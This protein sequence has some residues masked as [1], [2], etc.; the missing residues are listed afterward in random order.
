[1]HTFF[2]IKRLLFLLLVMIPGIASAQQG[3]YNASDPMLYQ[4]RKMA[5]INGKSRQASILPMLSKEVITDS[6]VFASPRNGRKGESCLA[7]SEKLFM[8][9]HSCK[10]GKITLYPDFSTD[11]GFSSSATSFI[12]GAGLGAALMADLGKHVSLGGHVKVSQYYVPSFSDAIMR[13]PGLTT[14]MG[15]AWYC[16][17]QGYRLLDYDF[18]LNYGFMKY[19][20]LEGGIGRNF[21]GD[22]YR[23]MF[24]SD[25]SFSYPYLKLT[26]SVWHIK[27]INLYAMLTNDRDNMPSLSKG[28]EYKYGSFHYLSWDV[29]KRVNI[30]FFETIIWQNSD[31]T[32]N[33]GFDVNYINPLIFYRPVEF[34]LGS[35]DNSMMGFSMKVKVGKKNFFYG[36]F[37]MDDIIWSEFTKGSLNR[38]K[39]WIHPADSVGNYGYWT[40]KQ[41]WQIGFISYDIF[42][43]QGLDLQFEYN[44]ARPYTYSH[45]RPEVNYTQMS[46]PLAHPAGANFSEFLGFMHYV[47]GSYYFELQGMLLYTGLDS[48]G[49]HY[50]A[51][52]MKPTFDTYYP[53]Y[54]NI[55]VKQYG[56]SIGQGI[57]SHTLLIA[58]KAGRMLIPAM[59]LRID[60]CLAYRAQSSILGSDKGILLSAGLRTSLHTMN[61]ER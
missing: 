53:E 25:A 23:S 35:P 44:A 36:Q 18:Y 16:G 15:K 60:L 57:K 33:R 30:G 38:I 24:L 31:S 40:N 26:T 2:P 12:G 34:S 1:M 8:L 17:D 4:A 54:N 52:I 3:Q 10:N 6:N 5:S 32:M 11:A 51:D 46:E 41:A 20:S 56:N 28:K 39:H 43:V 47:R 19:F 55:L 22:G 50:G 48:A 37:M 14:A 7:R 49:T 9:N 58:L 13:R 61:F 21:W 29:C 42:R 45:R 27:Y 59:N